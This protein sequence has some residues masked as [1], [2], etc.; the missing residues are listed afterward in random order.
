MT[1]S[2]WWRL[3]A[4]LMIEAGVLV[5]IAMLLAHRAKTTAWKKTIGQTVQLT[6]LLFLLCELT[7]MS[8]VAGGLMAIKQK[9]RD[10][11]AI[12]VQL[13]DFPPPPLDS[14]TKPRK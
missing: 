4:L 3:F 2:A 14:T 13:S 9:P 6:L 1:S 11:V 7:G 5:T 10:S 12:T 8:G